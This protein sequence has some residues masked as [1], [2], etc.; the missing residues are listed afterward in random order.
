MAEQEEERSRDDLSEE[1]SPFKLEEY[2]KKGQ[3]AQSRE[4]SGLLGLVATG[5]TLWLLVPYMKEDIATFMTEIFGYS[6]SSEFELSNKNILE[7][8]VL[9]AGKLAV[10]IAFPIGVIGFIVGALSSYIQVGSIFSTDP[11]TPDLNKIN[12]VKGIKRFF[13]L[14]QFYDG[15]RLVIRATAVSFVAFLFVKSQI[16]SSGRYAFVDPGSLFR[17]FENS[18]QIIFLSMCSVL[19]FF[20][21]LD[22][23][24]QRWEFSKNVRLTKREQKEEQKEHEGDPLIKARIRSIQRELARKRMMDAVKTADVV[25]TN[26]IH[27]AVALSYD[28]S[29]MK[30]PKVVAKGA[31]FLAQKIKAIAKEAGVP[32]VENLSLIHI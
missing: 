12:P 16:L 7:N 27:I 14:K 9:K 5:M 22:L 19:V 15:I 25:V 23:W 10:F 29:K 1:A 11:I 26:P 21:A 13:S 3:V 24:L 20:A 2:R 28:Q 32:T 18:S 17:T 6:F 31:D 8:T 30:S 4:L